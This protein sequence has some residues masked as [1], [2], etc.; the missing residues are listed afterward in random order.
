MRPHVSILLLIAL[1]T[2]LSC[3]PQVQIPIFPEPRLIKKGV[4][5]QYY[6]SFYPNDQAPPYGGIEYRQYGYRTKGRILEQ[7][8]DAGLL[9]VSSRTIE[10]GKSRATLLSE[11]AFIRQ[12][13]RTDTIESQITSPVF[14]SSDPDEMVTSTRQIYPNL[15]REIRNVTVSAADTLWEDKPALLLRRSLHLSVDRGEGE[16]SEY[17]IPASL[18]YVE[19]LGLVEARSQQ[20]GGEARLMLVAQMSEDEFQKLLAETPPRVG[21]IDTSIVLDNPDQFLPCLDPSFI[22]DYYNGEPDA[23]YN[24]GK[25]AL[26]RDIL[27]QFD[28]SLAADQSGY[29]TFRFVINCEGQTGWFAVESCSLDYQ[30]YEFLPELT[31]HLFHIVQSLDQWHPTIIA[32]EARD[33]YCYLTFK[34]DHG[35]LIDILP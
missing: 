31:T 10:I 21:F 12:P 4:V 15:V 27:P 16:L 14:W 32:G 29:L 23:G 17:E 18:L 9:P 20:P 30:A 13:W 19:G 6:F 34:F 8:Y 22:N 1:T 33:S 7:I 3:A 11:T 26:Y 5:N 25:Q 2:S 35:T 28:Q 24:G